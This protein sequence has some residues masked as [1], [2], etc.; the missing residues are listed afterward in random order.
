MKILTLPDSV[1][2][3]GVIGLLLS[4]D[5][6]PAWWFL[7]IHLADQHSAKG[8]SGPFC[9]SPKLSLCN[10]HPLLYC[11]T[12]SSC[13]SLSNSHL[14]CPQ[15]TRPDSLSLCSL[16]G[17]ALG[18]VQGQPKGLLL[19]F[20]GSTVLHCLWPSV[21]KPLFYVLCPVF[22][23]LQQ[24]DNL[25]PDTLSWPEVEV[26]YSKRRGSIDWYF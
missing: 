18:A 23:C 14:W 13:L 3:P 25:D 26:S 19:T 20:S 6:S 17:P 7:F 24:E 9:R 5:A 12:N 15:P 22:C 11:L 10:L 8:S 21:W 1:G 16:L 2:V 4:G